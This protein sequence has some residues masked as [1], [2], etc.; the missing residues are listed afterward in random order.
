MLRATLP[1]SSQHLPPKVFVEALTRAG[2]DLSREKLIATLEGFYEHETGATPRLTF[3]PN[4][5]VGA[6]GAH[7]ISLELAEKEFANASGLVKAYP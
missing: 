3:G 2:K 6:A 1:R 4:R 7:V 5:R